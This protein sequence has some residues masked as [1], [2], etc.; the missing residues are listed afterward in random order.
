M[1]RK[2]RNP[3]PD[4]GPTLDRIDDLDSLHEHGNTKKFYSHNRSAW[5]DYLLQFCKIMAFAQIMAIA[6]LFLLSILSESDATMSNQVAPATEMG[7]NGAIINKPKGLR[8]SKKKGVTEYIARF[9]G[10]KFPLGALI[11]FVPKSYSSHE[12]SAWIVSEQAIECRA[13][14]VDISHTDN[15]VMYLVAVDG[16]SGDAAMWLRE[17]EV[18]PAGRASTGVCALPGTPLARRAFEDEMHSVC[19]YKLEEFCMIG[20]GTHEATAADSTFNCYQVK[21]GSTELSPDFYRAQDLMAERGYCPFAKQMKWRPDSI[22]HPLCSTALGE[23]VRSTL[24]GVS[25]ISASTAGNVETTNSAL[26]TSQLSVLQ[27]SGH[28]PSPKTFRWTP[29]LLMYPLC[30]PGLAEL[31]AS[32]DMGVPCD[33]PPAG[34][35]SSDSTMHLAQLQDT[36]KSSFWSR[37]PYSGLVLWAPLDSF[38]PSCTQKIREVCTRRGGEIDMCQFDFKRRFSTQLQLAKT[39]LCPHPSTEFLWPYIS[40]NSLWKGRMQTLNGPKK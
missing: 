1:I 3:D 16:W 27:S 7:Q 24:A 18:E 23:A 39:K 37:C 14:I 25:H 17:Q 29:D 22:T 38:Y 26:L 13:Q 9:E 11:R 4:G 15:E 28:C 20:F 33:F 8:V 21:D 34:R 40:D 5:A 36:G 12:T 6:F 31:C 10:A 19:S 32:E 35:W 30:E 2:V